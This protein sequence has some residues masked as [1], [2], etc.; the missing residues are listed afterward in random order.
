VT[1]YK[2]TVGFA[3]PPADENTI[4]KG[5]H[6]C[7]GK[8]LRAYR[9]AGLR[10][11]RVSPWMF[12]STARLA[13]IPCQPLDVSSALLSNTGKYYKGTITPPKRY[14]GVIQKGVITERK[15]EIMSCDIVCQAH[16]RLI[17]L[18]RIMTHEEHCVCLVLIY[19]HLPRTL[20][21]SGAHLPS[22]SESSS[23]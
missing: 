18:V 13:C 8:G 12:Q 3:T 15:P 4:R 9:V 17:S 11:Y 1:S 20:C 2:T 22:S 6:V 21:V 14:K 5:G 23:T 10:A 19:P 7:A 16:M